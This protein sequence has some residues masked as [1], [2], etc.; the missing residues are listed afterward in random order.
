MTDDYVTADTGKAGFSFE[1]AS[2]D[3]DDGIIR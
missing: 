2:D 3:E 1:L